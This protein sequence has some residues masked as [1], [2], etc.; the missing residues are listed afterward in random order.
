MKKLVYILALALLMIGCED[1]MAN[2]AISQDEKIESFI[3]SKYPDAPCVFN[4]GVNRIVLEAGDSTA[5]AAVGDVVDFSY[6][7]YPFTSGPGSPF[8][9]GKHTARLGEGELIKGLDRGIVG[10]CPG[11]RSYIVFSC[12]YG[13]VKS[14]AGIGGDQALIFEV[15]LNDINPE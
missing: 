2:T 14:V 1:P 9:Q 3:T 6:I 10:M 15:L 13:Y 11:E 5:F 4:D 7:G 12:K 8:V